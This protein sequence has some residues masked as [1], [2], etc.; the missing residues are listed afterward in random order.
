MP[1]GKVEESFWDFARGLSRPGRELML[2]LLTC[3]H[4]TRLG[5]F[6]L[7]PMYAAADLRC[8]DYTP[9]P[10]Q[11]EN[12]LKELQAVEDPPPILY[13]GE[14]RV[15]WVRSFL[16]LNTLEN[17]KV[18]T[19]ALSQLE[20]LPDTPLFEQLLRSLKE[21]ERPHYEPLIL[22]VRNRIANRMGN[23]MPNGIGNG[24]FGSNGDWSDPEEGGASA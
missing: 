5:L 4:R 18:I 7:D 1:Y 6:V 2:F 11:I 15:V 8:R 3:R 17:H 10:R 21:W 16:R 22:A 14:T 9:T 24:T 19:G 12:A 23:G 20:G 13:D